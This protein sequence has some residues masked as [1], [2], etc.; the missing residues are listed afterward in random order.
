MWF[1]AFIHSLTI[2]EHIS[3]VFYTLNTAPET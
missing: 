3:S 2:L 1:V